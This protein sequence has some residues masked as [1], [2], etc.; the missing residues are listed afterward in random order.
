MSKFNVT[1]Y[2]GAHAQPLAQD[3]HQ[4]LILPDGQNVSG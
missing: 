4:D 1:L 2:T 3:M